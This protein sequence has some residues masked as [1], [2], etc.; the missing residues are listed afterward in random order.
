MPLELKVYYNRLSRIRCTE[1]MARRL[2]VFPFAETQVKLIQAQRLHRHHYL[3]RLNF[4][5]GNIFP[6]D[7]AFKANQL[8][9][10]EPPEMIPYPQCIDEYQVKKHSVANQDMNIDTEVKLEGGEEEGEE[11]GE[12]VNPHTKAKKKKLEKMIVDS[13]IQD[14]MAMVIQNKGKASEL[15]QRKAEFYLQ[16]TEPMV[17]EP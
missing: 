2:N 3:K 13:E 7:Q 12:E 14:T 9:G 5:L 10:R 4:L 16:T 1:D 8:M 15:M 6:G 17:I 11:E